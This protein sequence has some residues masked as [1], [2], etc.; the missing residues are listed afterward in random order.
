MDRTVL[1]RRLEVRDTAFGPISVKIAVLPDGTERATPEFEDCAAAAR[2]AGVPLTAV[3]AVS[4][5]HLDVYK[6]QVPG[7]GRLV[8]CSDGV[9]ESAD[10]GAGS[11]AAA[12][13]VTSVIAMRP[14]AP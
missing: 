7:R 3:M 2:A 1:P 10:G 5:T 14:C 6:R 9:V 12:A 11:A 13:S 8:G 4:Y